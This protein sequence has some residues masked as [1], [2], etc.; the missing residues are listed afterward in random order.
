MSKKTAKTETITLTDCGPVAHLEIPVQPGATILRGTSDLGKSE[1][2][3]AIS[4]LAGGDEEVSCRAG[5][6][7]GSV[8]G[9]GVKLGLTKTTRRTGTLEALAIED[10]FGLGTLIDGDNLKQPEAADRA[11]IKAL[12]RISGVKADP[13]E[14]HKILPGGKE[15]F[16]RLV[17]RKA[18]ET[19]DVVEMARRIKADLDTQS[20]AAE[21]AADTE[22]G[23]AEAL[24]NAGDGLDV[25]AEC[26][27]NRLQRDHTEAVQDF[28]QAKTEYEQWQRSQKAA[29]EARKQLEA[30]GMEA[31]P[32]RDYEQEVASCAKAME[33]AYAEVAGLREKIAAAEAAHR[34]AAK[35]YEHA[36]A[37][38]KA[39]V[40]QD[41]AMAGWQVAIDM[42]AGKAGP[43]AELLQFLKEAVDDCQA[44]IEKASLIRDAKAKLENAKQHTATAEELREKARSLRDAGKET[45]AVLSA[46]V[47]SPYLKVFGGRLVTTVEGRGDVLFHERSDGTRTRIAC[48]EK[49]HRIR[50][51]N[52]DQLAIIPIGQRQWNDL[53]PAAKK[54]LVSW[55]V[56]NNA[57]LIS[58]EVTD[59]PALTAEVVT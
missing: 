16:D 4:R 3:K 22:E 36:I 21:S 20:R 27:A 24:R 6:A 57:C 56:E 43:D 55:A 28:A 50:A 2:L 59:D 31:R 8:E 25:D 48:M 37:A 1:T 34:L 45:D 13:A 35:D 18:A 15:E 53:A 10:G 33:H 52:S 38:Q 17:S 42:A 14:F 44:A 7:R 32:L 11:R 40:R 12:L 47:A 51:I 49:L 5:V 41:E 23:K 9:F 39:A 46:L 29:A 26:D 19:D 54:E 30:A 58:A